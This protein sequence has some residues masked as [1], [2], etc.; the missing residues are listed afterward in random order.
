M[1]TWVRQDIHVEGR[2]EWVFAKLHTHGAPDREAASLLGEGGH[3]LHR[4][5][6]SK[7]NDGKNWVLHY[8]TA[9][10]MYNIAIA[11]MEGKAGDPGA[12]RD[13]VIP[14]PPVVG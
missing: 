13:Y 9:R 2:P 7:Y 4:E 6:T 11:A 10:E 3:A 12:Y 1:K 14:P 8:V 5:L